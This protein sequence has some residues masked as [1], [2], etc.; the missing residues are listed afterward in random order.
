MHSVNLDLLRATTPKDDPHAHHRAAHLADL[1]AARRLL[2]QDRIARLRA[3]IA[4]R[5][6]H[7]PHTCPDHQT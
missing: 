7:A 5:P 3:L 2:W 1:R 4:R 6:A